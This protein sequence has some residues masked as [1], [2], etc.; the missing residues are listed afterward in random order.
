[1]GKEKGRRS[2]GVLLFF[3]IPVCVCVCIVMGMC[4][5]VAGV[6]EFEGGGG[7]IRGLCVCSGATKT[8]VLVLSQKRVKIA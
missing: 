2:F 8:Q 7:E 1:M 3:F 4:E 6:R 5:R